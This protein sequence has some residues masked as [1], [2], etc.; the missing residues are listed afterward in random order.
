MHACVS[1]ST[2]GGGH[3]WPNVC[4]CIRH[5]HTHTHTHRRTGALAHI[6]ASVTCANQTI[7][8]A[9]YVTMSG[10]G[11]LDRAKIRQINFE[12]IPTVPC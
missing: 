10:A 7:M 4:A 3:R 1:S 8:R 9:L 6:S 11:A 5:A 2:R 12:S